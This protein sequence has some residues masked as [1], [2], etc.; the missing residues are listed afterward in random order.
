MASPSSGQHGAISAIL[1]DLGLKSQLHR[2]RGVHL[3]VIPRLTRDLDLVIE[4]A[5]DEPETRHFSTV[6]P[7]DTWSIERQLRFDAI[8]RNRLL[9]DR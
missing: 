9:S 4:L 7:R 3:S 8:K 1:G 5:V 6:S 2:R